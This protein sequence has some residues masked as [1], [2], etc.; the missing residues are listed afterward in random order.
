MKHATRRSLLTGLGSALLLLASW[1][2]ATAVAQA[3]PDKAI[4]LLVPLGS[5]SITDIIA[6]LV[7]ARLSE[8]LKQPVV[9]ENKTGAGGIVALR[10]LQQAR[11]DGYTVGLV[12]SGSTIQ[13]WTMKDF[14]FDV[15]KDFQ[16]LS[17]M[18]S[19]PLMLVV[20]A[21][22]PAQ[23]VSEF[24]ALVKAQPKKAFYG[25]SGTGTTTH[26]AVELLMQSA[27]VQMTHVPF[28]GSAEVYTAML[29]GNVNAY[30]DLYGTA[31]PLLE[32]GRVKVI[33]VASRT[34]MAVLPDVAPISDV[35]PD[36]EVTG[37]TA[38]AV[39]NGTPKPVADKLVAELRAVMQEPEFQQRLRKMGVEPG[40]NSP[41]E[42]SRYVATEY[43]KWGR[44]TRAAGLQAQ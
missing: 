40:G 25:S 13:P 43:D 19:G 21:D 17:L 6:R 7:A 3:F 20:P 9:I 32:A 27:S 16:L 35:V 39:P 37:W 36:F 29:S 5:G 28:K 24:L 4:H 11:P 44:V 41:E 10:A 33:G 14:P 34:R 31:K 12:Q 22:L 30:F 1:A 18:Y 42:I 8:R 23:N 26:L 2:P 38:F 15:R